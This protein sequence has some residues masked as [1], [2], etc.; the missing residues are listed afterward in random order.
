MR[1]ELGRG[2]LLVPIFAVLMTADASAQRWK[3]DLGVYGGYAW[4]TPFLDEGE[5]G[6]N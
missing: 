3:W 4:F 6:Q 2:L 5:I 1:R